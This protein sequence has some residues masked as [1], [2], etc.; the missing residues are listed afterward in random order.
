VP[1]GSMASASSAPVAARISFLVSIDP[2][3]FCA[4]PILLTRC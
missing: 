3:P 1:A 2:W 4:L